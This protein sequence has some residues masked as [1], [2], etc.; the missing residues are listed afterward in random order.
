[1]PAPKG[2]PPYNKKGEG[3]PPK[4]YTLEFIDNEADEF[5]K[6]MKKPDSLYYKEFA[7]ER[8]YHYARFS[9]FCEVSE[10]FA[11]AYLKAR[12]WQ[13]NKFLRGGLLNQFNAGFC[14]FVMANTCGWTE[15]SE[16]K[17]SG[18][19]VNPLAFVLKT[20][21]GDSKEL[22]DKDE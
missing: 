14:K 17:L 4:K 7:Y 10:K 20:I 16:T 21:D 11:D 1:M 18:D 22:I 6:W 2:H 15:K 5:E 12:M 13:E 8:G 9:E 3:G 19:A